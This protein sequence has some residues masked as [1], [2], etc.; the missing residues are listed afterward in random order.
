LANEPAY[1]KA[2]ARRGGAKD[3]AR[4]RS[5][6]RHATRLRTVK[7]TG[8]GE[9]RRR[10]GEGRRREEDASERSKARHATRFAP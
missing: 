7:R 5:E 8:Y 9:G 1:A 10:E 3:D 4:E 6:A 2:P